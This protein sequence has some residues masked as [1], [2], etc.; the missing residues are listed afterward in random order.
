MRFFFLLIGCL[1]PGLLFPFPET[2]YPVTDIPPGLQVNADFIVRLS[3]TRFDLKSLN[4]A[5]WTEHYVVTVFNEG[6]SEQAVLREYYNNYNSI[7]SIEGYMYNAEGTLLKEFKSGDIIDQSAVRD[8]SLYSD[9]RVKIIHPLSVSYP[10]TVEYFVEISARKIINCPEWRPLDDYRESIQSSKLSISAP[11]GLFPRIHTERLPDDVSIIGDGITGKTWEIRDMKALEREPYGPG[12]KQISPVLMAA[13]ANFSIKGYDGDFSTWKGVGLWMKSLY[14]GRDSLDSRFIENIRNDVDAETDTLVK[15]KI[16]YRYMQRTCRYVNTNVGIG[17]WQPER[18]ND[19]ARLGYGDCKGLVNY[20]YALLK[21]F[22]IKSFC[23]LVKAGANSGLIVRDFP[24]NQFNHVILAVPF[25]KDT[26]WLECT[27]PMQ[28]F[29]F[30]GSFTADRDAL[31]LTGNG[32]VLVRTPRYPEKVN[33]EHSTAEI[34][35]DSLGNASIS[36]ASSYKGLEF[37]E[38]ES[39]L[40]LNPEHLREKMK[41][42]LDVPGMTLISVQLTSEGDFLP[43]AVEKLGI[44]VK[45]YASMS[46]G[47]M[48]IPLDR[49]LEEPPLLKKNQFRKFELVLRKSYVHYD[50]VIIH[51][52]QGFSPESMQPSFRFNTKFGSIASEV[53]S[54]GL[55]VKLCRKL[56]MEEGSFP[57]SDFDAFADFLQQLSRHDKAKLVVKH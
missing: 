6:A 41:S 46:G 37:E 54:D 15:V 16:L 12:I 26:V 53:D 31:L 38:V 52:P 47:R 5:E 45:N 13:P 43:E 2:R 48:F 9:D 51:L 1:F 42:L 35:M 28:P 11:E 57:S 7:K 30:L 33:I 40:A 27:D 23:T 44:T 22:G 17:G 10:F 29:G 18:A 36:I 21:Q 34:R 50:T 25:K 39:L 24:S 4:H 20:T 49:F 8:G 19:V 55:T 3:E 32:G 56:E 14:E